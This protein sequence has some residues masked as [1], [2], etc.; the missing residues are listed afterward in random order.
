MT[1]SS[2]RHWARL[3]LLLAVASL[4]ATTAGGA[5]L[6]R[7]KLKL[8][9][10]TFLVEVAGSPH[11]REQ[12]LMDRTRLDDD[13]GMLFVFEKKERHCFWMSHTLLPLSIAFLANDGTI[14]ETADMQ[15]Q[16]ANLH[17][18]QTPVRFALEVKQGAFSSKGIL[19]GMR[20]TGGPFKP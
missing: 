3:A 7:L 12:G 6:P 5:P 9:P 18:P 14:L 15:P 19:P 10:N 8:G 2:P 11:Q 16:T 13:A 4:A 1:P 20:F 17:C